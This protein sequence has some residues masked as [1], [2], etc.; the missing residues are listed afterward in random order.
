MPIYSRRDCQLA[1]AL[2]RSSATG[3][4]HGNPDATGPTLTRPLNVSPG[5]GVLQPPQIPLY[6]SQ[7]AKT[8]VT[9]ERG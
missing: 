7:F 2:D 9:K 5:P 8:L 1:T 4:L 6:G 3:D